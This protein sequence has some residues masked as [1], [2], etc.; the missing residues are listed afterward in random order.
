MVSEAAAEDA[1]GEDAGGQGHFDERVAAR[2]VDGRA[3]FSWRGSVGAEALDP[4]PAGGV[5]RETDGTV[6]AVEIEGARGGR[7]GHAAIGGDAAGDVEELPAGE[8]TTGVC[9]SMS[10]NLHSGPTPAMV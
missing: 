7:R 3:L 10:I 1:G 6:F 5:G 9:S 4:G 8:K 2:E